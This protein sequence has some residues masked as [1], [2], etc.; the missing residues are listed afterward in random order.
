MLQ[1]NAALALPDTA[2][3]GKYRKNGKGRK[4]WDSDLFNKNLVN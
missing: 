4:D 1:T 3:E 2:D